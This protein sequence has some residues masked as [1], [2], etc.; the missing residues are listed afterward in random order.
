MGSTSTHGCCLLSPG[1][2]GAAGA[3]GS[4]MEAKSV[5][6][7]PPPSILK[8][9]KVASASCSLPQASATGRADPLAGLGCLCQ[10]HCR[11]LRCPFP[12]RLGSLQSGSKADEALL[13]GKEAFYPSQKYL[14]EKPS[15]LASTG[16]VP[17]SSCHRW[18]P[19]EHPQYHWEHPWGCGRQDWILPWLWEGAWRQQQ[20]GGMAK[21]VGCHLGKLRQ[22]MP[23]CMAMAGGTLVC[24]PLSFISR[25]G[26]LRRRVGEGFSGHG[27]AIFVPPAHPGG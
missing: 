16:K 9:M 3:H 2:P 25:G 12:S 1:W 15:L 13:L 19:Q 26:S 6:P 27:A 14:L 17:R 4:L 5:P 10:P 24:L 18:S 7:L 8:A 22:E 20:V 21:G 23:H 11:G